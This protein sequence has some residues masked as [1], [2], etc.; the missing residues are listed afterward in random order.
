MSNN[1]EQTLIQLAKAGNDDAFIELF[2]SNY[3]F[4]YNY[5]LKLT[6]NEE[7]SADL[8][9]E[10][11]LTCYEQLST[12]KG[13]SKLS[14]WII[15]IASRLYIDH[16]RKKKREGKWL[17]QTKVTLSRQL[18]WTAKNNGYEWSDTFTDF[19]QLD[20]DFRIPILLHHY[21]G[22]TYEE[23]GKLLKIRTGTVKSRVH[24]GLKKLRKEW[25]IHDEKE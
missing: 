14:T 20:D 7:I 21:Y 19:N 2:Q 18:N 5:L 6:L 24:N 10:T 9:Q 16:L 1:N 3:P 11:M 17:H 13:E 25:S 22:Y 4:L 12:F 15:S 8:A 23:I